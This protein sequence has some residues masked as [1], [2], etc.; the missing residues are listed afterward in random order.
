[1]DRAELMSMAAEKAA[2]ELSWKSI[3]FLF[4]PVTMFELLLRIDFDG[5]EKLA[6]DW[7]C[8]DSPEAMP[9]RY[10]EGPWKTI[11]RAIDVELFYRNIKSFAVPIEEKENE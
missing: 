6:H 9:K 2:N 10:R 5:T 7:L 1:M 3:E 8:D 4:Q 11:S